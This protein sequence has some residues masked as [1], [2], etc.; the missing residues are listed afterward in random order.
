[1]VEGSEA[2]AY[3]SLF[4]GTEA[5]DA[6]LGFSARRVG[7]AVALRATAVTTSLVVNRV[8]GLGVV[9]PA[10]DST[11]AD[12]IA[13]YG[14]G[15]ESFGVELSPAALPEDL[16]ARLR[17]HRLRKVFSTQILYRDATAPPPRYAAWT[18]ATGLRVDRVGPEQADTVAQICCEIFDM[19]AP[20]RA[21]LGIGSRGAGWRRWLA[22]DGDTAIGASVSYVQNGV[23]WLGWTSV[24]PSHRG[25][26]VHAGIVARQLDDAHAAGCD[27]V[28][29]E[30]AVSTKA[31]PDAAYHNLRNFGFRDAYLRPV[32]VYPAKRSAA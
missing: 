27:W 11:I 12:L 23:A 5:A 30:T 9:A 24:L 13:S 10:T 21:L 3:E 16:P 14:E 17:A 6:A 19:P 22:L 28:T 31:K 7:T 26:W 8:L 29:T 1:M 25:R 4:S 15:R 20:V 2:R 32:H 18:R